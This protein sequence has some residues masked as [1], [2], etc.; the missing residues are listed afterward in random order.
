MIP[1]II[2]DE[3]YHHTNQES[4]PGLLGYSSWLQHVC[5]NHIPSDSQYFTIPQCPLMKPAEVPEAGRSAWQGKVRVQNDRR[6][7]RRKKGVLRTRS[8]T[9]GFQ[10][11]IG[12]PPQ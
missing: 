8:M 4:S 7:K 3:I 5:D 10:R 11:V 9:G 1:T 12:I 2:N 6:K